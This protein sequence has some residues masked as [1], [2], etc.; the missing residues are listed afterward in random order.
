VPFGRIRALVLRYQ[1]QLRISCNCSF[2][3][4]D[5]I[6]VCEGSGA[7]G[8]PCVRVVEVLDLTP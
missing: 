6:A 4:I 2:E 3:T 5:R 7:A 1:V 8:L